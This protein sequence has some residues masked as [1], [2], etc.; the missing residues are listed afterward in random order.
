[1]FGCLI[2]LIGA[3]VPIFLPINVWAQGAIIAISV[4]WGIVRLLWKLSE[5]LYRPLSDNLNEA[6]GF[7]RKGG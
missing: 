5:A 4:V 7:R 3:V 6:L 1:M 2:L